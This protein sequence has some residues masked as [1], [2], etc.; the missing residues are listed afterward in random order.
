[1]ARRALRARV[2]QVRAGELHGRRQRRHAAGRRV[3]DRAQRIADAA[4]ALARQPRVVAAGL[5]LDGDVDDAARVGDEVRRPQHAAAREQV[6]DRLVGQLVVGRPRDDRRLQRGHGLVVEDGAQGARRQH[7]DRGEQRLL[8]LEPARPQAGGLVALARVDVGDQELG[9]AAGQEPGEA[10]ADGAEPD[11]G[12][13][14]TLDRR[15]PEGPLDRGQDGGLDAERRPGAGVARAAAGAREAGDVRG[16]PG[17]DG[18]VPRGGPDILGRDVAP[19]D[20]RDRVGEVEQR[21]G[22]VAPVRRPVGE[23]DHALAAA[24]RQ[25]RDGRLVGHRT[26][27]SQRVAHGQAA[28]VVA[29]HPASAEGRAAGRGVHR[30]DA[31]A[32]RAGPAPDEQ[33][34]VLELGQVAVHRRAR[35]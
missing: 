17:D 35:R 6:G 27:Q 23:H 31:V 20:R 33:L 34:L 2:R 10:Q 22:A 12:R 19:V 9:P 16:A 24:E 13:A 11:D 18:H 3:V 14:A 29:P 5:E 30:D 21:G 1:V 15:A 7:V 32:P 25:P 4:D 28:V 8:G 26:R